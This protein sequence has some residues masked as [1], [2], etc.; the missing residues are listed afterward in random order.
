[1]GQLMG[2]LRRHEAG[3]LHGAA[4]P[5]IEDRDA[6]SIGRLNPA[7]IHEHRQLADLAAGEIGGHHE[8]GE[9]HPRQAPAVAP[10]QG[11]LAA[12]D[13]FRPR[14][15]S[16][17]PARSFVR[18]LSR[19]IGGLPGPLAL[20]GCLLAVATSRRAGHWGAPPADG[21]GPQKGSSA[22]SPGST[23]TAG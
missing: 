12:R 15:C 4:A 13:G 14:Q 21:T 7:G 5:A 6:L 19:W 11:G 10:W 3:P 16:P 9:G 8:G 18:S 22:S 20:L 23:G 1:M 2:Q 17:T